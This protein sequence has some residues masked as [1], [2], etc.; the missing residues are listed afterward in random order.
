MWQEA[1]KVGV[2]V[3][4]SATPTIPPANRS[5][6]TRTMAV[7]ISQSFQVRLGGDVPD[8]ELSV[9]RNCFHLRVEFVSDK[10][11]CTVR[12]GSFARIVSSPDTSMGER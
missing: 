7:R 9:I 8:T 3:W 2:L 1:Q 11:C 4:R 5:K 6:P 12:A 10:S